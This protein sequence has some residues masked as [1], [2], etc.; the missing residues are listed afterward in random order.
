M[1]GEMLRRGAEEGDKGGKGCFF[2]GHT[3][4]VVGLMKLKEQLQSTEAE[5]GCPGQ[6]RTSMRQQVGRKADESQ[7][8]PLTG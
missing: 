1:K 2:T 7:G 8:V 4:A 5:H 6:G 3:A